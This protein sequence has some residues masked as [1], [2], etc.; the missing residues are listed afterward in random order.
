MG[1]AM[2]YNIKMAGAE[3]THKREVFKSKLAEGLAK[4]SNYPKNLFNVVTVSEGPNGTTTAE[5][6][7]L[8]N[9]AKKGSPQAI[10]EDLALQVCPVPDGPSF[11]YPS[12]T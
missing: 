3:G 12:V 2:K 6:E 10:A 5:V 1:M 9:K 7:I 8:P 4:A 11:H